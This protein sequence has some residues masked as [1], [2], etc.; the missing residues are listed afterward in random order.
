MYKTKTPATGGFFSKLKP[1]TG[2]KEMFKDGTGL[3]YVP[4]KLNQA[5]QWT[6]GTKLFS[7]ES[8]LGNLGFR[9]TKDDVFRATEL[10]NIGY[11]AYGMWG[12][13]FP[14]GLV[15][16]TG[17][18]VTYPLKYGL[19]GASEVI[20]GTLIGVEGAV[21]VG[22]KL[23]KM[24]VLTLGGQHVIPLFAKFAVQPLDDAI[25][26]KIVPYVE[27][28]IEKYQHGTGAN[29]KRTTLKKEKPA[30]SGTTSGSKGAVYHKKPPAQKPA[31][32]QDDANTTNTSD[33]M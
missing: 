27:D 29:K 14:I 13:R 31:P 23:G 19:T 2:V 25:K 26:E 17:H 8:A 7:K 16:G 33:G 4:R 18:L 28:Q 3:G 11:G 32:K 20:G 24:S 22:L 1:E 9:Y 30:P 21:G 5:A 15:S 12:L 10:G 6:R